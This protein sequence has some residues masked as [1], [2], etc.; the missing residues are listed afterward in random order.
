MRLFKTTNKNTQESFL[1][2]VT[3]KSELEPLE[4]FETREELPTAQLRYRNHEFFNSELV[5][6][7]V[8]RVIENF[9]EFFFEPVPHISNSAFV[10]IGQNKRPLRAA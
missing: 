5:G 10:E 2:L 3:T 7:T 4:D 9:G 8:K 6:V 1:S